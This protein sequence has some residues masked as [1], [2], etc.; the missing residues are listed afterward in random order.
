MK[1]IIAI[2]QPHRLEAVKASLS[3]IEVFRGQEYTVNLLRKVQLMIAVNDEFAEPTIEAVS[4]A[5]RTGD[6]GVLRGAARHE[7]P[8]SGRLRGRPVAGPCPFET[9][10]AHSRFARHDRR[11]D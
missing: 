2:I 9:G 4:K 5:G 7:G 8:G 3:D 1:L 6:E 10:V 11:A